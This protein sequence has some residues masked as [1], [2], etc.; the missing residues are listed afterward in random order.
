MS[1]QVRVYDNTYAVPF[2]AN[3]N[4]VVSPSVPYYFTGYNFLK[5]KTIKAISIMDVYGINFVAAG[6]MLT[7]R[8]GKGEDLLFNYPLT[9]LQVGGFTTGSNTKRLRLFN[10]YD[11]DLN[12]SYYS[13]SVTIAYG[14]NARIFI[15]N[16]HY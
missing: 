2:D 1:K 6:M 15:I 7:L 14:F 11:I 8:N 12:N 13:Q 9:D 5:N 16:F 4:L 10:L 3:L